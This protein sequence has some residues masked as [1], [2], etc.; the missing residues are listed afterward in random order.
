MKYA[1]I[2]AT[3]AVVPGDSALALDERNWRN[4]LRLPRARW[5]QSRTVDVLSGHDGAQT[6]GIGFARGLGS[7]KGAAAD[8]DQPDY[9]ESLGLGSTFLRHSPAPRRA[10]SCSRRSGGIQTKGGV[11]RYR[12]DCHRKKNSAANAGRISDRRFHQ[13]SNRRGGAGTANRRT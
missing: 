13:D 10:L 1:T 12:P 5:S 4:I 7:V 11:G 6:I 3:N 9:A 8:M 2:F